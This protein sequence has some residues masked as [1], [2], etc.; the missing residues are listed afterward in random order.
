MN[1]GN[2][3]VA[4][5]TKRFKREAVRNGNMNNQNSK[6]RKKE[7]SHLNNGQTRARPDVQFECAFPCF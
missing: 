6:Q 3:L 2:R 4:S 1:H 7:G 5:R